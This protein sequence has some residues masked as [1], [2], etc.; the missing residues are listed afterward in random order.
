MK[1]KFLFICILIIIILGAII[2][3]FK[4]NQEYLININYNEYLEKVNKKENFILY[5]KQTDCPH[6]QSFT[7]KFK[8]VLQ[9]YRVTAYVLNLTNITKEE[10]TKLKEQLSFEGTPIVCFFEEGYELGAFAR[11]N[12]NK[13][14]KTIINKLT[15]R[16][17]IPE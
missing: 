6:C 2:I 15:L 8:N 17:Y 10:Y 1:H 3:L 13:S 12:G 4:D 11:I 5:I 7:P 14:E 16:G 9:K